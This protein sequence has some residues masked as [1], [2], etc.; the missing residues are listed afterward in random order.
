L[1]PETLTLPLTN[2]TMKN[3]VLK[4]A[5]ITALLMA[6]QLSTSCVSKSEQ[7]SESHDHAKPDSTAVAYVCPMHPD[8][9]GKEG[10]TC[11]KCGMKLEAAKTTDTTDHAHE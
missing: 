8:V 10:D 7:T 2:L 6:A 11:S 1:K 4:A 5:F 9:T 3:P